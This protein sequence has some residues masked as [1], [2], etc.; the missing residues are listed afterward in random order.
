MNKCVAPEM[1][2]KASGVEKRA[3]HGGESAIDAFDFSILVGTVVPGWFKGVPGVEDYL[4]KGRT[5]AEFTALVN[6][7]SPV[8]L[9]QSVFL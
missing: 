3:N 2:I 4:T 6:T 7:D 1:G 9:F 8:A 5:G